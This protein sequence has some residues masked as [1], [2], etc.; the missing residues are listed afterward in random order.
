MGVTDFELCDER[1]AV[2]DAIYL[3]AEP[4]NV[5]RSGGGRRE[6]CEVA[7]D[8]PHHGQK[9][10]PHSEWNQSR[11][12]FSPARRISRSVRPRKLRRV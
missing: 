3:H 8:F 10:A 2:A 4:M 12:H 1:K 6:R 7:A 11:Q 5:V 9:G